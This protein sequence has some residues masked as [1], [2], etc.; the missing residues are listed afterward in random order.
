VRPI[1]VLAFLAAAVLLTAVAPAPWVFE[2]E[3]SRIEM[4]V[5]AFGGSHAG[6]FSEW[7]GEAELDPARPETARAT[8]TVQ[9]GSLRMSPAAVTQRAT[10]PAFLDA[11]RHP[12]IRFQLKSLEPL[13]GSRYSARAEVTVKGR[14]R[15]I[16][17]PVDLRIAGDQ[18]RLTGAFSLDRADFGIGTAGPWDRL[19]GRQVTVR[20]ALQARPA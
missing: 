17:F 4:S 14:R 3:G 9:A 19:V 12:T 6:R 13:G 20:V 15:E 8:V 11:A 1:R 5:R 16:A 7:G 18:A 10:G 2:R